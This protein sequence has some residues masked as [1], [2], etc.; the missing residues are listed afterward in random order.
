MN[1]PD[2][3]RAVKLVPSQAGIYA[4]Y[5]GT[6]SL[7]VAYVGTA[8]PSSRL[9]HRYTDAI[10]K[11]D[12]DRRRPTFGTIVDGYKGTV[13]SYDPALAN[14]LGHTRM[15]PGS[16]S[17]RCSPSTFTRVKPTRRSSSRTSLY[18]PFRSRT[19]GALTVKRA[20][21]GSRRTWSTIFS[22]L[23][24]STRRPQASPCGRQPRSDRW[25]RQS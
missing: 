17:R 23:W 22:S 4:L 7:F 20:P 11:I 10:V 13:E 5:G 18:S 6:G 25:R 19:T 15:R 24:P 9:Q 12:L 1:R 16:S 2:L 3:V 14:Q 21:S 8:D